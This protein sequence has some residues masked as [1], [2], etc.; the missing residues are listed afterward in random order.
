MAQSSSS[1]SPT[2]M[3]EQYH[4]IKAEHPDAILFFRLGDFYEMFFEDAEVASK[5]LEI[6]LTSRN[7]NKTSIPMCGVPAHAA[8][9]YLT[10]LVKAGYKVAIC[11]QVESPEEAKGIV[12]RE[13]IKILTPG[14]ITTEGSLESKAN[15]FLVSIHREIH[16]KTV[17][18]GISCLDLSTGD[19]KTTELNSADDLLEE[20]FRLDPKEILLPEYLK[21]HKI[22]NKLKEILPHVYISYERDHWFNYTKSEEIIKEHFKILTLDG[23]G[24]IDMKAA[25]VA[26]GALLRY[27]LK[28]QKSISASIGTLTPYQLSNY[29]ILDESTQRNLELAAN[30]FDQTRKSTLLEVI[31][32]TVTSMGGRLLKHWLIYPLKNLNGIRHRHAV[33]SIFLEDT[34]CRSNIRKLLDKIYDIERL[35][36]KICLGT[37]NGRDLLAIKNSLENIPNIKEQIRSLSSCPVLLDNIEKRLDP[38]QD[39]VKL[40]KRSIRPDCP[41]HIRDGKVIKFG[42]SEKLDTLLKIQQDARSYLANIE[43]KERETTGIASL[44]IGFNKVFGYYIEVTKSNI[45]SVPNHYIRKQTLVSA[46]RYITPELKK[47]EAKI[48]SASEQSIILEQKIFNSILAEIKSNAGRIQETA[49]ALAELDCLTSLA[50]VAD[51]YHYSRPKIGEFNEIEIINGRHPVVELNLGPGQFVPNDTILNHKDQQLLIITGPNMAGKSTILRQTALI[52]LL[53]QM[54]SFVPAERARI[55]IVDRIF[56]RVGATDHLSMGRS[57]FMVEM[58][59]TANILHNATS[60]SLVILDEIGRGTSTYDGLSI[61]WAVAEYLLEKDKGIKTMFATHYHELTRLAD[62]NPKVKNLHVAVR[63]W[64][65]K[66]VFLHQFKTGA[67]NKSYGIQV[68]ALAGIPE[69]VINRAKEILRNIE[70]EDLN[71]WG[72]PSIARP[73]T[74]PVNKEATQMLLPIFSGRA[75]EIER[76]ILSIDPNQITPIDALNLIVE[77][78]DMAKGEK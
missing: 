33:V 7:K 18:W 13:V 69:K 72:E 11:E 54:G 67:T 14:L 70:T 24:L 55:G 65:D 76:R 78:Q 34:S 30:T 74:K 28:T 16:K 73:R 5:I 51:R 20:L 71:I 52:V 46:E 68:A 45:K 6:T 38:L 58:S 21:D 41:V 23:F 75:Q 56:T 61:A 26:S 15:N 59:E 43:A 22:V 36:S 19:F 17:S 9:P 8:E 47:I 35:L 66:I 60:R 63:E 3:L 31:D 77:L 12:R 39:I 48:L 37:A 4:Q 25:I 1:M 64:Q 2:P 53:A 49:K 50:A 44:K 42:Y 27:V 10:K 40:I 62:E 29:L 57:T 32:Q